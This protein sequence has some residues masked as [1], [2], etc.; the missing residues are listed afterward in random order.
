MQALDAILRRVCADGRQDALF[1]GGLP[2]ALEACSRTLIGVHCP[3]FYLEFPLAGEPCL[4]VLA[5]YGGH[6]DGAR[7]EPGAGYGHQR[8]FDW[9]GR[10]EREVGDIGYGFE[11]DTSRGTP[12][13][14][15][16]YFQPN[17]RTDL[18]APFLQLVGEGRRYGAYRSFVDRMPRGWLAFYVGIFPG[19][20]GSPLRVGG[21]LNGDARRACAAN[22]SAVASCFERLGF[23]AYDD[24]MLQH[25][26]EL[27][28]SA[29]RVVDFQF[30]L[31]PDGGVDGLFAL[32]ISYQ[33]ALPPRVASFMEEGVGASTMA[34]LEG[35]G[36]A[37]GRWRLVPGCTFAC[38]LP[39]AQESSAQDERGIVL[40]CLPD[41]VKA[42]WK[43]TSMQPA[44]F[45]L[46]AVV[47]GL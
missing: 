37:D 16:I 31:M 29:P 33:D 36:V 38:G 5:V 30:N 40:A 6:E 1:G 42:K 19:R 4:D 39:A 12:S 13:A 41:F 8:T 22:P 45:Y 26:S 24:E 3:D 47:D 20:P 17:Y 34:L 7:F 32:D 43:G 14:A 10:M 23:T 2:V 46:R 11:L 27:I 25:I 44:K 35:W 28:A 18:V 21:Y 15:G 9:F